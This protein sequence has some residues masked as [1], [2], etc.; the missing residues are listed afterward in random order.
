MVCSRTADTTV[1]SALD[2]E[3]RQRIDRTFS[4]GGESARSVA[5]TYL[6]S[7]R[8][9]G[10]PIAQQ[11]GEKRFVYLDS[12]GNRL[13]KEEAMALAGGVAYY[14]EAADPSKGRLRRHGGFVSELDARTIVEVSR[15]GIDVASIR[16]LDR[17]DG[18][19]H[20][21]EED[22][23]EPQ[24]DKAKTVALT[25]KIGN[26]KLLSRLFLLVL[27]GAISS[28]LWPAG[29]REVVLS[30]PGGNVDGRSAVSPEMAALLNADRM[31][32][33]A[34]REV[35]S[36]ALLDV[37]ATKDSSSLEERRRRAAVEVDRILSSRSERDILGPGPATHQRQEFQRIVLLLHPDK[38]L[39][40]A[41]DGRAAD[42]LR[43][44]FAARRRRSVTA[45]S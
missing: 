41:S 43:L 40:S 39:V 3:I 8:L 14:S 22:M 26:A 15:A 27:L 37:P 19:S 10:I 33:V 4:Q 36:E 38:G 28:S 30:T 16:D 29:K 1:G 31:A 42:A 5:L 11:V 35:L 45:N 24:K 12:N 2:L 21:V 18:N 13:T 6:S 44:A 34:I 20:S 9:D 32:T 25:E 23:E 17:F 7:K